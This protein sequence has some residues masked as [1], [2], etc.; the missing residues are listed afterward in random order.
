MK[1]FIIILLTCVLFFSCQ[2]EKIEVGANVSETF[3]VKNKGA[4][5]RVLVEGNTASKTILLFV[6]GGPGSSSYLYNTE[7]VSNH[8]EDKYAIAYWDHRNAGASQG[9]NADNFNLPTMTE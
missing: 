5:M 8:I 7:Y 6:H 9:N 2:K 3:Y 4:S 1:H